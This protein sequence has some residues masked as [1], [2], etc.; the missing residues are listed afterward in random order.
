MGRKK[1][2]KTDEEQQYAR[3]KRNKRYYDKHKQQI[4]E[5][6]MQR[7]YAKKDGGDLRIKK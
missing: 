6:A 4:N 2:Y 5:I 7:Y 3:S 1:I